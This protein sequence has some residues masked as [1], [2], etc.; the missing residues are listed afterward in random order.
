MYSARDH[1]SIPLPE[2]AARKSKIFS[3][4][5]TWKRATRCQ[6]NLILLVLCLTVISVFVYS[7]QISKIEK[8]E[9]ENLNVLRKKKD[10]K[11]WTVAKDIDIDTNDGNINR[12]PQ[13]GDEQKQVIKDLENKIQ[14][15]FKKKTVV[16]RGPPFRGGPKKGP[17]DDHMVPVD[18]D[19][20]PDVPNVKEMNSKEK[21]V[22]ADARVNGK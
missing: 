14:M 7:S 3:I 16:K 17:S 20:V 2:S 19:I 18:L 11:K 1:V 5:R 6:K 9:A 21:N 4:S 15:D 13:L 10:K 8:E 12:L 22:E